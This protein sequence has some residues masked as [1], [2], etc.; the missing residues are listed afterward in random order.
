MKH[1]F[2]KSNL[3]IQVQDMLLH[4][5]GDPIYSQKTERLNKTI[6]NNLKAGTSPTCNPDCCCLFNADVAEASGQI[7]FHKQMIR[8]Q[9]LSEPPQTT[10]DAGSQVCL[11]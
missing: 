9:S 2:N 5:N 4:P 3:T 8:F 6:L 7:F 1:S 10:A 11:L